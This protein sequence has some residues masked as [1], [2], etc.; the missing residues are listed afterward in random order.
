MPAIDFPARF[1][2]ANEKEDRLILVIKMLTSKTRFG[3]DTQLEICK[4][5]ENKLIMERKTEE[6]RYIIRIHVLCIVTQY[7]MFVVSV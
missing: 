7:A 1:D 4:C 5:F 3:I 6:I 2:L